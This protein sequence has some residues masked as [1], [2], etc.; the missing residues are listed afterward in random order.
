MHHEALYNLQFFNPYIKDFPDNQYSELMD[1]FKNLSDLDK[2]EF[3]GQIRDEIKQLKINILK[4]NK[5][6]EAKEIMPLMH[7]IMFLVTYFLSR[8]SKY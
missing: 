7:I 8:C 5:D 4:E 3:L 1:S 6:D 2:N